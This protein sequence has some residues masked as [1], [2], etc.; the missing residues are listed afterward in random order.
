MELKLATPSNKGDDTHTTVTLAS[1]SDVED[2][3]AQGS[4]HARN[5]GDSDPSWVDDEDAIGSMLG[6]DVKSFMLLP[7]D[8]YLFIK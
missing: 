3:K 4:N 8:S 6:A 5:L 1:S 2:L 7:N